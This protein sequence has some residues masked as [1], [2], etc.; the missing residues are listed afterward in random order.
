MVSKRV[1][2]DT[3]NSVYNCLYNMHFFHIV[4]TVPNR[5]K[6]RNTALDTMISIIFLQ[7]QIVS[8]TFRVHA[9]KTLFSKCS[10]HFQIVL[11]TVRM[12]AL[13]TLFSK[14]SLK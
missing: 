9:L 11:N 4:P 8:D 12:H 1:R 14:L 10:L 7:F 2:Y 5:F 13:E 3:N 6:Y